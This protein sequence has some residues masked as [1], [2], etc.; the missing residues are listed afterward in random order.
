MGATT[1]GPSGRPARGQ[2]AAQLQ[3]Q[4][5]QHRAELPIKSDADAQANASANAQAN[6]SADADADASAN[7]DADAQA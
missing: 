7:A 2:P 4:L 5:A 1:Q 6:A 3:K